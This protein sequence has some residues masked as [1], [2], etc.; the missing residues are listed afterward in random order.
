[1]ILTYSSKAA[2]RP[3]GN[4][5]A[6]DNT[7]KENVAKL[8]KQCTSVEV[9]EEVAAVRPLTHW[10]GDSRWNQAF[11]PTL[12]HALYTSCDPFN[13]FIKRSG[14]LLKV[15]QQVFDLLFP[16]INY[17]LMSY[18]PIVTAVSLWFCI[19]FLSLTFIV[20]SGILSS[21]DKEVKYQ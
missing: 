3:R 18:D 12:S 6:K 2:K 5:T 14:A 20:P 4:A 17:T 21:Q 19:S 1:M 16:N 8:L 9:T 15:T 11:I 7:S 10:T 13:G